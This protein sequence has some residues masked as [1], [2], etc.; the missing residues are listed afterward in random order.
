[1]TIRNEK[2]RR[3][4][5]GSYYTISGAGGDL[6][7]WKE[8]YASIMRERG[9]GAISEWIAFTGKEM[10]EEFGLTGTNAYPDNL[11][12]LAFPLDGL[13]IGKLAIFKL[14]MGDRWFDDIVINDLWREGR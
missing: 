4:F 1:M 8:G 14:S 3:A 5:D 12:F 6:N 2:L 7:D 13:N 11:H 9:I 10:N